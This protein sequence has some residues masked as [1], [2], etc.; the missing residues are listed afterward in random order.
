VKG[1]R[2]P[3]SRA[4]DG[5]VVP[6]VDSGESSATVILTLEVVSPQP[7]SLGT[8]A[9]QSFGPEGGTIGRARSSDW[10]L[11]HS[12]VS[13]RHAVITCVNGVYS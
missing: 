9:R 6:A 2:E 8:A 5:V 13:N 11:P 4:Q 3:C 10:V 12:K 7:A 1:I